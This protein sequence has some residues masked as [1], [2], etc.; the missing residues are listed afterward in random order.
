MVSTTQCCSSQ[1]PPRRRATGERR[2]HVNVAG[3]L[4][5]DN[6]FGDVGKRVFEPSVEEIINRDPEVL[7]ATFVPKEST[8]PNSEAAAAE[9][10]S[11]AELA[12]VTAIQDEA[13]IPFRYAYIEAAPLAVKGLELLADRLAPTS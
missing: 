10:K 13:V 8:I 11:R 4:G 5:F 1:P 6:V 7:V 12:T 3:L 2:R 9:V